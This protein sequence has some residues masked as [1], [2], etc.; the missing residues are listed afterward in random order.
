M[1][2]QVEAADQYFKRAIQSD[3]QDL[4]TLFKVCVLLISCLFPYIDKLLYDHY[5][6]HYIIL[7]FIY[8][9]RGPTV[10]CI[11]GRKEE[12][13]GGSRALLSYHTWERPQQQPLFAALWWLLGES[14]WDPYIQSTRKYVTCVTKR[15]HHHIYSPFSPFSSSYFIAISLIK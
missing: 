15:A 2:A 11:S 13:N 1:F 7:L 10:C 3:P 6:I 9:T 14:R 4:N 8:T 5:I 12:G